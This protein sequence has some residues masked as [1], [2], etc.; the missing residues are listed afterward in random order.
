MSAAATIP[1]VHDSAAAKVTPRSR[2]SRQPSRRASSR[3]A[4]STRRQAQPRPHRQRHE[5]ACV[6][7][8]LVG[9]AGCCTSPG[10][11]E[12]GEADARERRR[13]HAAP[14][15]WTSDSVIPAHASSR[16]VRGTRR[17]AAQ[18]PPS[19]SRHASRAGGPG[20]NTQRAR[21]AWAPPDPPQSLD[22]GQHSS[23]F[24]HEGLAQ[25]LGDRV[26]VPCRGGGRLQARREAGVGLQRRSEGTGAPPRA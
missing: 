3:R 10:L 22:G 1:P 11:R 9:R 26:R 20:S 25:H 15:S 6:P 8:P 2:A 5:R 7:A 12:H 14:R 4:R 21:R 19:S 18:A 16:A 13:A 17:E 23:A 24:E